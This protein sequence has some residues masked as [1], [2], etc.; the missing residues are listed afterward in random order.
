MSG[1]DFSH[2]A[3]AV[4]GHVLN[5]CTSSFG[6]TWI[7]VLEEDNDHPAVPVPSDSIRTIVMCDFCL[8]E[9]ARWVLPVENYSIEPGGQNVG[10]WQSCDDCAALL[11]RDDWDGLTRRAFA[12]AL[13]RGQTEGL[14]WDVFEEMYRQLRGHVIASVRPYQG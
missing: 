1:A 5:R 3:C 10:N 11:G 7:H 2:T 12:A 8:V 6:E 14:H 9:G 4:C 13:E